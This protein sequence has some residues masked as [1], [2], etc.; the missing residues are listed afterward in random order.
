MMSPIYLDNAATTY[1]KP[2]EVIDAVNDC[3]NNFAFNPLRGH[4][5]LVGKANAILNQTRSVLADFFEVSSEQLVFVPSATYGINLV[6]QGLPLLPGDTI[7]ISPYEHNSVLRC[8]EY[9]KK[10]KD[11]N[12]K[13]LPFSKTGELIIQEAERWFASSLPKLVVITHASNVTGDFLPV[14]ETL[15]LTHSFGGKVL[16]DAAQT[17]GLY[18]PTI[19]NLNYDY[20][21]FSSHKGL[22]GIPG[23]G[24]LIIKDSA[25]SLKPLIFGGTG[26]NSEDLNMP[27]TLP[28]KFEAGTYPLPAIIS[29]H[30][31]IT[32][33]NKIGF[34]NAKAKTKM[35]ETH[36][37]DGLSSLGARVFGHNSAAENIGVISF[38]IPGLT[39]QEI[40]NVLDMEN[41]CV[42]SGLHCSPL[43]HKTL[44]TLPNGTVRVSF[45]LFNKMEEIT[46]LLEVLESV[47]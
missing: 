2:P 24:G 6:L 39:P 17:A 37:K 41:I 35:L 45:G 34:E 28:E 15:E 12:L 46:L 36:L 3:L 30:A 40:N 29:M 27:T 19:N 5:N 31:G 44:G 21:A 13:L 4:N 8:A 14:R 25:D 33:L 32:Y 10:T 42:R 22:Y 43:A 18:T 11:I 23:S 7:Y 1:P 47:C 38:V 9:L 20:L 26:F 16:V